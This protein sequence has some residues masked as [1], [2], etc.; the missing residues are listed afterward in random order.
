M[1]ADR[2]DNLD[3]SDQLAVALSARA[4]QA[5]GT[6]LTPELAR[7]H[8]TRPLLLL[9]E[10]VA[11]IQGLAPLLAGTLA[12]PTYLDEHERAVKR[13]MHAAASGSLP[14]PCSPTELAQW[15]S[16]DGVEL[17]QAFL[18]PLSRPTNSVTPP[19]PR[20]SPKQ[21][22]RRDCQL[23]AIGLWRRKETLTIEKMLTEKG[24]RSY[25]QKYTPDTVRK[26]LSEVD[27]RPQEGKPGPRRKYRTSD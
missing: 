17:P 2:G 4:A 12:G 26:W 15:A 8:A 5:R 21:V 13:L 27:S 14:M 1:A 16:A 9:E 22:D 6:A 11:I 19:P 7:E 23:M 18:D 10:S 24:V 3:T 20:L 25:A